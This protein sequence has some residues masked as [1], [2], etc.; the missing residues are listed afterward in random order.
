[1]QLPITGISRLNTAPFLYKKFQNVLPDTA[2]VP[3][4][5]PARMQTAKTYTLPTIEAGI[6]PKVQKNYPAG[7]MSERSALCDT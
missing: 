3:S 2:P 4:L 5:I 6:N 1:M 7:V